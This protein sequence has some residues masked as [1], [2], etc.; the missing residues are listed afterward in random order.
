[1]SHAAGQSIRPMSA[2][3]LGRVKTPA[4]HDGVE[5]RS[6]WPTVRPPLARLASRGPLVRAAETPQPPRFVHFRRVAHVPQFTLPCTHRLR[7]LMTSC[8]SDLPSKA[9]VVSRH[10]KR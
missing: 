7:D 10:A 6:H 8:W 2:V 1:M 5:L 3:G 4:R 9:E